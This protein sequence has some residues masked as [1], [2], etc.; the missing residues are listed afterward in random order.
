[1]TKRMFGFLLITL[2]VIGIGLSYR[3]KLSHAERLGAGTPLDNQ[4]HSK[5]DVLSPTEQATPLPTNTSS[6]AIIG[7]PVAKVASNAPIIMTSSTV[8]TTPTAEP[9]ARSPEL[10]NLQLGVMLSLAAQ[11]YANGGPAALATLKSAEALA[12]GGIKAKIA[13]LREHTPA[14]GP[15]TPA[16]LMVEAQRIRGQGAPEGTED[17]APEKSGWFSNLVLIRNVQPKPTLSWSR[18]LSAALLQLAANNPKGCADQLN[19]APLKADKRLDDIRTA[20]SDYVEQND[21]LAAVLTAYA[22]QTGAE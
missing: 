9:A 11:Q 18:A 5:I 13:S 14:N 12:T 21:A 22:S 2:A 3:Y 16:V 20:L 15:I 8:I 10:T 17:T 7:E 6:S 4:S 19:E 1:M